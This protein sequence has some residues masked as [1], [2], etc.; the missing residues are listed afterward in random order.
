MKNGKVF[1][2]SR[3]PCHDGPVEVIPNLFCGSLEES[4]QMV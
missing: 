3:P 4:T 2:W 1:R